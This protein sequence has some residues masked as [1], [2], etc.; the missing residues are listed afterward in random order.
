[1]LI[2]LTTFIL[3][4]TLVF[5][6]FNFLAGNDISLLL[7]AA[8]AIILIFLDSFYSEG[9]N[10]SLAVYDLSGYRKTVKRIE[11]S[12]RFALF[13][14]TF[15][16][17]TTAFFVSNSFC[18]DSITIPDIREIKPFSAEANYLSLEGYIISYCRGRGLEV[19]RGEARRIVKEARTT[20][21]THFTISDRRITEPEHYKPIKISPQVT[22]VE[23]S[24]IINADETEPNKRSFRTYRKI[25]TGNNDE[26]VN[27]SV[28]KSHFSSDTIPPKRKL[29]I[30]QNRVA[31]LPFIN[32][33]GNN[34]AAEEVMAAVKREMRR[35]G[36][37]MATI[38]PEIL[39]T[40]GER[41]LT[42]SELEKISKYLGVD[43][44]I[45]GKVSRYTRYKRFRLAGFIV[46]GIY[47]GVH[48]YGDIEASTRIF[49]RSESSFVYN[50]SIVQCNKQQIMGLFTGT[51]AVM[52]RT[53][54]RAVRNL[55]KNFRKKAVD[56][57]EIG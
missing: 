23:N 26:N 55:Y 30:Q 34:E 35:R 57:E 22:Y 48:N 37:T 21:E 54:E 32:D 46:G 25:D 24:T 51:G 50:N 5:S 11:C 7:I 18:D 47:T 27:L 38:D 33:S 42:E 52:R 15:F 39:N 40:Y 17:G 49:S 56:D 4:C 1:M 36:F 14:M 9:S 28:S 19:S 41:E 53:V 12:N 45:T 6:I 3:K 13:A 8:Q 31:V 43:I 44:V 2:F 16:L 29:H 20:G 10:G